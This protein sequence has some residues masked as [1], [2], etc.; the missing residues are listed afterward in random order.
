MDFKQ[1]LDRAG[2]E[3]LDAGRNTVIAVVAF[4]VMLAAGWAV[5]HISDSAV[6]IANLTQTTMLALVAT[7]VGI[8]ARQIGLI[9]LCQASF[10]GISAYTVGILLRLQ[11][12][13]PEVSVIIAVLFPVVVAFVVGLLFVRLTGISFVMVTLAFGQGFF[14]LVLKWRTLANG[15]DGLIVK[16]PREL[17]G[18]PTKLIYAPPTM[19]L[20]CWSILCVVLLVWKLVSLSGIGILTIAVRENDERVR[21]MGYSTRLIRATTFAAASVVASIAGILFVIRDGFVSP[22][23]LHWSASGN[24]LVMALVGGI[25]SVIGPAIGALVYFLLKL[26]V[27]SLTSHWPLIFGLLLMLVVMVFPA[28][29]AGLVR[30]LFVRIREWRK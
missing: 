13:S 14:E 17:F 27:G 18:I 30:Q 28:G 22:D 16:L 26:F 3:A 12:A 21:F 1:G 4:V 20:I 5:V 29:F 15:D 2:A 9:S 8:V 23:L 24:A 7:S 11:M 10:F 6:L 25:G 19:F